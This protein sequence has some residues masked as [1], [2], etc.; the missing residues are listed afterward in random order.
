[1]GKQLGNRQCSDNTDEPTVV[2]DAVVAIASL[3]LNL[4]FRVR[5]MTGGCCTLWI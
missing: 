4:M 1:M 3:M 5:E 2:M